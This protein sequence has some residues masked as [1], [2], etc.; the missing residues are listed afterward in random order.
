M[1]SMNNENGKNS[2]QNPSPALTP[3]Q[4]ES[5]LASVLQSSLEPLRAEICMNTQRVLHLEDH[6]QTLS[7]DLAMWPQH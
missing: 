2:S 5:A 4:W 3:K 7:E 6:V 1:E